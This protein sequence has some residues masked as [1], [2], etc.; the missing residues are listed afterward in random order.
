MKPFSYARATDVPSALSQAQSPAS[1]F[2]AGG[3]NLIDLMKY[4][5]EQPSRLVDIARLDLAQISD[6]AGG[7]RLGALAKNSDTANHPLVR[8]RYPLLSQAILSGASPQLR[9]AASNGGNILQRTRCYYFYDSFMP[10]NKREPGT[11][12]SA[13]HGFNRDH[14]I[15]GASEQCIATHP[16]DMAVALAALQARVEVQSSSG[17]RQIA[18]ADFHR[19]PGDT[20]QFDTNLKSGELITA[21]FLPADTAGFAGHSYYLKIRDRSSYAFALVSVAAAL[22]LDGDTIREARVALG[23]V[24]HMPWRKAEAEE[25]LRGGRAEDATFAKAAEVLLRG[26]EPH[27]HNAFKIEMARRAVASALRTAATGNV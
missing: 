6:D 8:E 1:R 14:A 10:C 24:A 22:V 17:T 21:I 27:E 2:L 19:L 15:L 3:T 5:V 23:G 7:L 9:N 16:S 11:G 18:F 13:L 20:P 12:C 4:N 26:A 25:A